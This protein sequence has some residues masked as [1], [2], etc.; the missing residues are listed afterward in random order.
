M[1]RSITVAFWVLLGLLAITAVLAIATFKYGAVC[2]WAAL[3]AALG[4]TVLA[5]LAWWGLR[6]ARQQAAL[7][8][9]AEA[10]ANVKFTPLA[11]LG[12]FHMSYSDETASAATAAPS[13]V[14][15]EDITTLD[16][17]FQRVIVGL[18]SLGFLVLAGIIGLLVYRDFAAV[19]PGHPIVIS[20]TPLDPGAVVA[21]GTALLIYILLI[22]FS[23]PRP[24][25]EGLVDASNS[26]VILGIPG[27]IALL[28]AVIA[29]WA[30]VEYASQ[31]AAMF[32]SAILILQAF[33]LGINSIRSHGGIVELDQ[34]G[35]DLQ[36]L[37]LVPML[38]SGWIV[39]IRVLVVESIGMASSGTTVVA[40]FSRLIPRI[41][42]AGFLFV[43]LLSTMHVV[44]TGEV[45][46]R[47]HL[48]VT[49][50]ADLAHPLNPGLHILWPWP[51]DKLQYEPTDKVNLVVVGSEERAKNI[52]GNNAFSFWSQHVSIPDQEFLT[53]DVNPD[54]S[55]ASQLLDGF[56][57]AWWRVKNPGEF[58]GNVSTSNIIEV[59]GLTGAGSTLHFRRMD[60]ALV[61]QVL[62]YAVTRVFA[63]NTLKQIMERNVGP[64]S[65]AIKKVMQKT[66]DKMKSGIVILS[67]EI[68]DIHPP[69]GQT[70]NTA[71]GVLL[72]PAQAFENVVA[73]REVEEQLVDN[74]QT[75][76]YADVAQAEG[77]AKSKLLLAN[78]YATK[79]VNI[80]QGRAKALTVQST[81]FAKARP[82]AM[83]WAFYQALGKMFGRVNKVVLGPDVTPPEIWQIGH[84]QGSLM[85]P[86][87]SGPPGGIGSAGGVGN[88]AGASSGSPQ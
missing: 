66:L 23:R 8:D 49:T 45:G 37:P 6:L 30:K 71:Q 75:K 55:P 39:G 25:T 64:V 67:V 4:Q 80:E 87:P 41:V 42:I 2:F 19:S 26:I 11:P 58:F 59:G 5:A 17:G 51:I 43:V 29:V 61:H 73:Q 34:A 54:G 83:S 74:A 76:A 72:G 44:P 65:Q 46:I 40:I 12:A 86:P 53:G 56:V 38:S 24:D 28:A 20:P 35:V 52:L 85:V 88:T 32:I 3:F 77:Y 15:P 27:A 16:T 22:P 84:R 33:E 60:T 50:K 47:E 18:T 68:K 69:A 7:V 14:E 10:E 79:V 21:A 81:A 31:A 9:E 70:Q 13:V 62:L 63:Q 82:A 57:A 78:G 48:G 36:Q 1:K